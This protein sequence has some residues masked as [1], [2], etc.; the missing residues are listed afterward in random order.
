MDTLQDAIVEG[1]ESIFAG[2]N[3][4]FLVWIDLCVPWENKEASIDD[5]KARHWD[6]YLEAQAFAAAA[7]FERYLQVER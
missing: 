4:N 5:L 3:E 2:T 6:D 1:R 7:D